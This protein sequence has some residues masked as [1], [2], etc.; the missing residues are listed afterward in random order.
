MRKFLSLIRI[1]SFVPLVVY[2]V[3]RFQ[4]DT[5]L[6]AWLALAYPCSLIV[7][8]IYYR[9]FDHYGTLIESILRDDWNLLTDDGNAGRWWNIWHYRKFKDP[10][11]TVGQKV[12]A[13]VM[14]IVVLSVTGLVI[15]GIVAAM[16]N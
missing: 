5:D 2:L 4:F 8:W 15:V 16:S 3:A 14:R 6:P 1:A 10:Y 13:W 7:S 9:L 11:G 12:K